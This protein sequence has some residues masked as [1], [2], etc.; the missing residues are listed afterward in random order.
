MSR[1]TLRYRYRYLR[2]IEGCGPF[3]AAVAA[4]ITWLKF[5]E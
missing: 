1:K 4:L 3:T 5:G 2:D